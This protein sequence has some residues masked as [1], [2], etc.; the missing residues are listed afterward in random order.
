M[1]SVER[2]TEG[3]VTYQVDVLDCGYRLGVAGERFQDGRWQR[4]AYAT[5]SPTPDARLKAVQ[6][7]RDAMKSAEKADDQA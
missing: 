5:R 1:S 4:V 6:V 7:I 3:D 2:W